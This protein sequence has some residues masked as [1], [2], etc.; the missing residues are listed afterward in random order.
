MDIIYLQCDARYNKW[1]LEK[2][3]G[4][5]VVQHTIERCMKIGSENE[6]GILAGIYGCAEN[7]ELISLLNDQGIEVVVSEEEDVNKRFLDLIGEKQADYV[8]RVGGDQCLIDDRAVTGI[9]QSMRESAMEFFYEYH[10]S[11]VLPDVVSADCLKK[12]RTE[13]EEED[14]YFHFLDKNHDV[15]RY[16]LSYPPLLL[17]HFRANSNEGF[18]VCRNIIKHGLGV[19]EASQN[20]ASS[21]M[22]SS[23]LVGTGLL[24]SWVIA[25]YA[26]E[27]FYDESGEVNPW[28]G[29]SVID[30]VKK[31][32]NKSLRVFEWG[33]GNSTL[34]WARNVKEVVS[35]DHDRHWHEK[36][37]EAVPGNVILKYYELEY[38]G[39]Y[40][41]AVLDEEGGFDIIL[42]DG[43]D[44]VR[45]ARNAVQRLN[46][47]GIIIWDD[48]EREAYNPGYKFLK[49]NGFKQLEINSI[50]YG[51]PGFA[52]SGSI[53]YKDGNLLGL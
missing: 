48:T 26:E 25:R 50:K 11:S 46:A 51:L 35:V 24:G 5:C 44:R 23:Y 14:R 20:L 33:S 1:L 3:G 39:R 15:K 10:T 30:L 21:L 52:G 6:C 22:S 49:E 53:F 45:C 31:H 43:R 19:Y 16:R 28:W 4:K 27:F 42:I 9:V 2:I 38:G 13:L 8:I 41:K 29:R 37:S 36:M 17:F 7:Q 32:L 47:G 34:F 12:W 18:R 40:C